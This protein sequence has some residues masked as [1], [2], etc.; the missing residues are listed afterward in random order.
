MI[1]PASPI[2]PRFFDGNNRN[3]PSQFRNGGFV[4]DDG[5][6]VDDEPRNNRTNNN[7]PIRPRKKI[8]WKNIK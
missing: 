4:F 2:A 7:Q 8:K 6:V 3:K 1:I 5:E